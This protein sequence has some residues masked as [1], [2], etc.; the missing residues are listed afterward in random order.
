MNGNRCEPFLGL[1]LGSNK[2]LFETNASTNILRTVLDV[3]VHQEF[4]SGNDYGSV[5]EDFVFVVF[6]FFVW[7]SKHT[8]RT[9]ASC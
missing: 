3:V 1:S 7:C 5:L 6:G 8:P 4:D 2:S 9:C